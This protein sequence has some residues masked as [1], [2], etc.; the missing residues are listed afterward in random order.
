MPSYLTTPSTTSTASVSLQATYSRPTSPRR[1]SPAVLDKRKSKRIAQMLDRTGTARQVA[2]I[3]G[4]GATQ[5]RIAQSLATRL[6]ERDVALIVAD[7]AGAIQLA[8][9]V[10]DDFGREGV[11]FL[12]LGDVIVSGYGLAGDDTIRVGELTGALRFL[13]SAI[14][15]ADLASRAPPQDVAGDFHAVLR[16]NIESVT[17][18]VATRRVRYESPLELA[19]FVPPVVIATTSALA[20][21]IFSLKRMYAIDL[22]FRTHREEHRA[23]FLEAKKRSEEAERALREGND[24]K[25]WP[26]GMIEAIVATVEDTTRPWSSSLKPDQIALVDEDDDADDEAREEPIPQV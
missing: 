25:S 15:I 2:R 17:A 4:R 14:A 1:S 26:P 11:S 19:L 21:L 5:T 12:A 13:A 8:R 9:I 16:G 23:A 24:A 7:Y 3:L 10:A 20:A 22:E 6:T 18:L